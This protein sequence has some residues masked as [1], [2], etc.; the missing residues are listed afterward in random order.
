MEPT[1]DIINVYASEDGES[2]FRRLVLTPSATHIS[3]EGKTV[4]ERILDMNGGSG[5]IMFRSA[6]G[7]D[8]NDAHCAPCRQFVVILSGS[9]TIT[10]SD[11]ESH[12]F[13]PGEFFLVEDTFGKGHSSYAVDRTGFYVPVCEQF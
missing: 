13:G 5:Q 7:V 11:G 8:A 3:V 6:P 2:H 9:L 10:V 1:M 12:T 4:F